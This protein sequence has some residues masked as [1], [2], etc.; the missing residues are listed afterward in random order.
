MLR[1]NHITSL[2][3]FSQIS[4]RVIITEILC[5]HMFERQRQDRAEHNMHVRLVWLGEQTRSVCVRNGLK[6]GG[7]PWQQTSLSMRSAKKLDIFEYAYSMRSNE[8]LERTTPLIAK[9][10]RCCVKPATR[11]H[12][13]LVWKIL[14]ASKSAWA[15]TYNSVCWGKRK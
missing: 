12:N 10:M 15:Y 5:G 3:W 9:N 4:H 2:T 7:L 11:S 14:L 6:L 8:T 1:Q 13:L